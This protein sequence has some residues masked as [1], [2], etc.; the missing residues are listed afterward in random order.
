MSSSSNPESAAA[1]AACRP[2]FVA[3]AHQLADA[4]AA[5]T[6]RYFRTAVPV[7]VKSDASPV[8]IA[9]REAE[10]AMRQLIMQHCPQH[11]IFGEEQGYH[12]GSSSSSSSGGDGGGGSGGVA[13]AAAASPYLWVIDPIDGTKS[14]I[15]GGQGEG[16]GEARQFNPSRARPRSHRLPS[17]PLAAP[18]PCLQASRCL[19]R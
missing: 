13:A 17:L 14:F 9:D 12:A 6:T 19:A 5:V 8:T 2:E 3:L 10:S 4:A 1:A 16:R 15:T 7:D 18:P 11:S